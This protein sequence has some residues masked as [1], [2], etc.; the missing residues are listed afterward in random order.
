[1]RH[2]LQPE[3]LESAWQSGCSPRVGTLRCQA[4]RA[5]WLPTEVAQG[6]PRRCTASRRCPAH[7]ACCSCGR[8]DFGFR[9]ARFRVLSSTVSGFGQRGFRLWAEGFRVLGTGGLASGCLGSNAYEP[10]PSNAYGPKPS[11]AYGPIPPI[12]PL[13][14]PYS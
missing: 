10:I 3:K 4:L 8:T 6:R 5:T 9:A 7:G 11:N 1:M 12:M 2:L 13:I 14:H